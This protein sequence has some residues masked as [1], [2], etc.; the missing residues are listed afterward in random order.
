MSFFVTIGE[1]SVIAAGTVVTK[2]VP[3]NPVMAGNPG[4]V[5]KK[6]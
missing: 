6:I 5:I 1:N 4:K 3:P 2:D